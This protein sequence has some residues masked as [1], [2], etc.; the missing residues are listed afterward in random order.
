MDEGS[1]VDAGE[2]ESTPLLL[3]E[4]QKRRGEA[5]SA[6][7]RGKCEGYD[8][9]RADREGD[10]RSRSVSGRSIGDALFSETLVWIPVMLSLTGLPWS[11]HVAWSALFHSFA[12]SDGSSNG[13]NATLQGCVLTQDSHGGRDPGRAVAGSSTAGLLY[14]IAGPKFISFAAAWTSAIILCVVC[15]L[16]MSRLRRAW[17]AALSRNATDVSRRSV[18]VTSPALRGLLPLVP[19]KDEVAAHFEWR[20]GPVTDVLLVHDN[21]RMLHLRRRAALIRQKAKSIERRA[22]LLRPLRGIGTLWLCRTC[23][24]LASWAGENQLARLRLELERVV[25]LIHAEA[26]REPEAVGV[27]IVTFA[28]ARAAETALRGTAGRLPDSVIT[29]GSSDSWFTPGV[30]HD[31]QGELGTVGSK[32]LLRRPPSPL[33]INMEAF[34]PGSARLGISAAGSTSFGMVLFRGASFHAAAF[35]LGICCLMLTRYGGLGGGGKALLLFFVV[36]TCVRLLVSWAVASSGDAILSVSV[37]YTTAER[38]RMWLAVSLTWAL[39]SPIVFGSWLNADIPSGEDAAVSFISRS[40]ASACAALALWLPFGMRVAFPAAREVWAIT[41]EHLQVPSSA[42]RQAYSLGQGYFVNMTSV[43]VA[44]VCAPM[45]PAVL[46]LAAAMHTFGRPRELALMRS[47]RDA[48]GAAISVSATHTLLPLGAALYTGSAF[49]RL[50]A[51]PC[52]V[53]SEL[54]ATA[55]AFAIGVLL[56]IFSFL[57]QY[58]RWFRQPPPIRR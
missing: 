31:P 43:L 35:A 20:F 47:G 14:G 39:L 19:D 15:W 45:C 25:D 24:R 51:L 7:R 37:T 54:A 23:R 16:Y 17:G 41:R 33:D 13:T 50:D 49:V 36:E 12:E 2:L 30:N 44:W 3:V 29:R 5:A 18:L 28:S 46:W 8:D 4:R 6:P 40:R 42:P 48:H 11:F 53:T 55:I 38:A 52:T 9:S 10:Q 27:A 58:G 21:G 32:M 56:A 34:Q 26:G 57:L 22:N 1:D